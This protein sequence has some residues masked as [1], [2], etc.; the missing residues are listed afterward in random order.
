MQE[1]ELEDCLYSADQVREL[2]RMAIEECG[3]TGL[4][5]MRQAAEAC[6]QLLTKEWP[7]VK[8]ISVFCGSGNN[9]G[10]GYILAGLLAERGFKVEV[11]VVGATEK[12]GADAVSAY[13]FCTGT[14][15]LL[16]DFDPAIRLN[17]EL[18]VDALLGTGLKGAVRPGYSDAVEIINRSALP[19]LAVDIPSGLCADTGSTLG[20]CIKATVTVTFIGLK[21]GL[22]TGEGPE[23]CGNIVFNDLAVPPEIYSRFR[24]EVFRLDIDKLKS[25][26]E[27][28]HRN[29]HKGNF[30]H[31]LVVGGDDS[32]PGA[33][34]M[35]S[36]AALRMG[37][38]LV[39]VATRKQHLGA[40]I[41]RRPEVMVAAVDNG[42]QLKPLLAKA[43]AVLAGPGL[44]QS[45]WSRELWKCVLESTLPL[46]VD[47]DAL[48]LLAESGTV[49]RENWILTPHP[50]EAGRLLKSAGH[51]FDSQTAGVQ[52]DRFKAVHQL[53]STYGG[54]VLLKGVG[55]LIA[56]EG[57]AI[58]GALTEEKVTEG[59]AREIMVTL[60]PYGNPGMATAGMGDV[61]SGVIGS[62]VAQGYPL[63]FAAE[64][65]ACL[66][67]KAADIC[68]EEEGEKGLLATDLM[69]FLRALL[70]R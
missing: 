58:E 30:G 40:I 50:G 15:T 69:P 2:D 53:Q 70:N 31:L 37:A 60:C 55:T 59:T 52:K 20:N 25:Q 23:M 33:V 9:A 49:Q 43:T 3:L 42:R 46:V 12:L 36:E 34:A 10:D 4:A 45:S 64:T 44:G 29:A 61:L 41:S 21:K 66:H 39:T 1:Y 14:N 32:M 16:R 56:T 68:A 62:L 19:V 47:A 57:T 35:A 17:G 48:N 13:E 67:S 5:L 38:G 63:K 26:L 65:G 6:Y 28:R 27:P 11:I 18:V 54:V 22:F 51:K 7:G 8:S 24:P